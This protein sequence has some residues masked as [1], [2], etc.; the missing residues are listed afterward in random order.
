MLCD[1][2]EDDHSFVPLIQSSV[3]KFWELIPKNQSIFGAEVLS[4]HPDF[5]RD[6]SR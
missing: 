3:T 5:N 2:K 4:G 6:D 1:D